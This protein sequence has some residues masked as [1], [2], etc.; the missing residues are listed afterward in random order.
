ME[1]IPRVHPVTDWE[2]ILRVHERI[3]SLTGFENAGFPGSQ[4]VSIDQRSITMLQNPY[5]VSWKA[6]GTRY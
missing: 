5:M 3:K 2:I 4:P 6:D 1:G